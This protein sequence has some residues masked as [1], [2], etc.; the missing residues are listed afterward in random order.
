MPAPAWGRSRFLRDFTDLLSRGGACRGGRRVGAGSVPVPLPAGP[1]AGLGSAQL[2]SAGPGR[3]WQ[4]RRGRGRSGCARLGATP[5]PPV[6]GCWEEPQPL[7][8]PQGNLEKPALVEKGEG[9]GGKGRKRGQ[10]SVP[11]SLSR[12]HPCSRGPRS[13]RS[14]P[15]K[16]YAPFQGCSP[17]PQSCSPCRLIHKAKCFSVR[18][19]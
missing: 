10:R 8:G 3:A 2:S 6:I 11:P 13:G 9:M 7:I 19:L 16:A 4:Q 15:S 18:K 1:A 14:Q 17:F 5:G 12:A